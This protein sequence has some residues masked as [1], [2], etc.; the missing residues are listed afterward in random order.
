MGV[1]DGVGRASFECE[2]VVQAKRDAMGRNEERECEAAGRAGVGL[3]R[4][5]DYN[6]NS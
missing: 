1:S 5:L 4:I 2:V 6:T 3:A